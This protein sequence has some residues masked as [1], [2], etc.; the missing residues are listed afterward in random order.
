MTVAAQIEPTPFIRFDASFCCSGTPMAIPVTVRLLTV[1]K[2]HFLHSRPLP[3]L[4]A[5]T[6]HKVSEPR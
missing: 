3:C 1:H 6:L 5:R 2:S 4:D